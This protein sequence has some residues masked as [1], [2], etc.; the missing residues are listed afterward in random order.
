M[1]TNNVWDERRGSQQQNQE[2]WEEYEREGERERERRRENKRHKH[3]FFQFFQ[4]GERGGKT[5]IP[6]VTIPNPF[7]VTEDNLK[8]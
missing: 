3:D 2:S 6:S 4:G 5:E 1:Q 7:H 8:G